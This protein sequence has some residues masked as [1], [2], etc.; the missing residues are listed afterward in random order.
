MSENGLDTSGT[1]WIS[2]GF[3]NLVDRVRQAPQEVHFDILIVGSGYGGAMAA[4]T[5]AGRQNSGQPIKP[6]LLE[7]GKEYLPGSF[8]R[9]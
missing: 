7:R 1:A 2:K 8:P 9:T 3:E 4:R 6:A 5:F